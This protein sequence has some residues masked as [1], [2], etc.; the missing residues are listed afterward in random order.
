MKKSKL[1]IAILTILSITLAIT[2][3]AIPQVGVYEFHGTPG[4][5]KIL[6]VKTAN[7]GSLGK[8]FGPGYVNVL[9]TAFGAGCLVEGA[10]KKSL[11]TAVNF[12]AKFDASAQVFPVFGLPLY[13]AALYNTSNWDWTTGAF[14]TTPDSVGDV[15]ISF[16]DPADLITYINTFYT[17]YF[18]TPY[19]ISL[20][21]AGAYFAQLPT[22]VEQYLGAMIW[23][24]KWEN[25]GNTIVHHAVAGDF[26]VPL[27]TFQYVENCT[28]TWTY[29]TTY[30]AW[31]GYKIEANA[32]TVYEFSIFLAV[33]IPGFDF[34]IT[35][36]V[37]MVGI[38]GIIFVLMKKKKI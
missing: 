32:T 16:Y 37:T 21:T 2:P 13:D 5:V 25:F 11:V 28:E 36:G 29:D 34:S 20:H 31:I 4:A 27:Y 26:N 22:N 6:K 1:M 38:I 12:S 3:A 35:L 30:G 10:K 8:I 9:E 18:A 23:E 33:G 17:T 15:V 14:S 7:N 19:N 24:P